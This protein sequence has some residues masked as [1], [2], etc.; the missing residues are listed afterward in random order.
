MTTNLD[1]RQARTFVVQG[2]DQRL[3]F[4]QND[5]FL[6]LVEAHFPVKIIARGDNIVVE[7][8]GRE[9]DRVFRL[10]GDFVTRL[11][12]GDYLSEQYVHYAI[13]MVKENGFG[14]A[15]Y[16]STEQLLTN[17]LKKVIKPKTIGQSKYVEAVEKNDIVFSIGPAGTGKTYLAVAMAVAELKA[18]K[19]NR[20]VFTRPAVEA[21]ESLGFLP[22]D[23]RAKVDPYLRPVYDAL[24]DML[25]PDKIRKL[26]ELGIIEIAPL[27]FMRGR[28][29][30]E[31]FVVLD[32]AQNTTSPQMKMFLTRI[33]EKSKAIITGDITQIDLEDRRKSGLVR[34]QKILAGLDGI[35]FI[36][37]TEKDVIR[38]HLVQSIIK[39]YEKYEKSRR[40]D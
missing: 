32:E 4:G 3:L 24:Y 19:V 15:E 2:I 13:S 40:K 7:G 34:V 6:R 1:D 28:T 25:Q 27:A 36:Y 33:G 22:G 31:A 23:I 26:L 38:H 30:N 37:L 14:P 12:Q 35:K 21:G 20:I 9:V 10:L 29:L 5:V 18:K 8:P 17:S 16:I 11:K 39:A